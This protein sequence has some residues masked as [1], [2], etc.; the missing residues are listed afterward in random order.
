MNS[1][2]KNFAVA[3]LLMLGVSAFNTQG[4]AQ[5]YG[6][7]TVVGSVSGS[8]DAGEAYELWKSSA[9]SFR[10]YLAGWRDMGWKDN[11][12]DYSYNEL[13]NKCLDEARRQYGRYYPNLYL[14]NFD[15]DIKEENLEDIEYYSQVV[16]SSTQFRKKDRVKRIY[17]YSASVV[18]A[19]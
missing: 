18:V 3:L 7:E 17:K 13:Y 11:R 6:T 8:V 10:E 9:D 14:K 12:K 4:F 16:G 5:S 1:F 19:E 2:T 15:Y